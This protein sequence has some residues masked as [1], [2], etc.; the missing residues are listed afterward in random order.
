MSL[1]LRTSSSV[2]AADGAGRDGA[3]DG[4]T[5]NVGAGLLA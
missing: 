4:G 5:T 2:V 1:A 3:T